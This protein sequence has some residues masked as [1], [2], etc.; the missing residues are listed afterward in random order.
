MNL[1][2]LNGSVPGSI[3]YEGEG[4]YANLKASTTGEI[5]ALVLAYGMN[6]GMPAEYHSGGT[7]PGVLES[8]RR[9][10]AEA[11]SDGVDSII[12]TTPH[13][14]STRTP[15]GYGGPVAYPDGQLIPDA[16][17]AASVVQVTSRS[18]ATVPASYRHLRVNESL[19]V[20]AAETGSLLLD[21][22]AFWFDAVALYGEDALFND[23]EYA[24]PNLLG[25]QSSYWKVI[26]ELV[27]A[28]T[29]PYI[30]AAPGD[31][32][33]I[34]FETLGARGISIASGGT[35]L[36]PI[37]ANTVGD[38]IIWAT[39]GG[40]WHSVYQGSVVANDT[41]VTV[42]QDSTGFTF[43]GNA[44]SS[45]AGDDDSLNISVVATATGAGGNLAYAYRY[46]KPAI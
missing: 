4:A 25:H 43:P 28:L 16:T 5:V 46:F 44:I 17:L 32:G 2:P 30:Q 7:F 40:A 12:M 13:P 6:D 31:R 41:R 22:E 23:G 14:H 26:D 1:S 19:R 21:V 15:W 39:S 11:D 27:V 37:P 18:G 3:L 35:T 9:L 45:V 20:L 8:G 29:A 38:I 42:T 36:I 10:I 33:A 34:S 24:H